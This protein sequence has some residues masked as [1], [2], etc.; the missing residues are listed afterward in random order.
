MVINL[1][2]KEHM[3]SKCTGEFLRNRKECFWYKKS[4]YF[5]E[6]RFYRKEIGMCDSLSAQ[7]DELPDENENLFN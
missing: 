6:C 1:C 7:K 5:D 4:S 3:Y 2:K